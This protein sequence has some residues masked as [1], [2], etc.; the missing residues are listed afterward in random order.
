MRY[1]AR[2]L[3][4]VVVVLGVATCF[5]PGSHVVPR[6]YA[7]AQGG[8]TVHPPLTAM[9]GRL[10]QTNQL[11][12]NTVN[13]VFL[14]A[15]NALNAYTDGQRIVVTTALWRAL[16]TDDERAFVVSHEL[17]HITL[18]HV[19]KSV[20]RQVGFR[21]LG[22]A[23]GLWTANPVASNVSNIGLELTNRKFGR[24]DEYQADDLGLRYMR[25]AGYNTMAAKRVFEVLH[26]ASPGNTPEFL[27]TH[28]NSD[29]RIERLLRQNP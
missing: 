17:A 9:V 14:Q 25:R 11:P 6:S 10:L 21:L 18:S 19:P 12:A 22:G 1:R 5:Q 26:A 27:R 23:I 20:A 29:K 7:A 8:L 24:N 16:T 2:L 13:Q 15:D 4:M 28:P 3:A